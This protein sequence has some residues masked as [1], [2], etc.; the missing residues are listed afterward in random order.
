MVAGQDN[1]QI[2]N[3]KE[4]RARDDF[5]LTGTSAF[6]QEVKTIYGEGKVFLKKNGAA[7]IGCLFGDKQDTYLFFSLSLSSSFAKIN[8]KWT[9][10][11]GTKAI[12]YLEK[13]VREHFRSLG[14][15]QML[16]ESQE[17]LITKDSWDICLQQSRKLLLVR[18]LSKRAGETTFSPFNS[19]GCFPQNPGLV[20]RAHMAAYNNLSLHF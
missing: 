13:R 8:L 6:V 19:T 17:E 3:R 5:T 9:T 10:D 1:W 14:Y 4:P 15:K 20:P 16:G 11:P 12:T 18:D 2:T 7:F